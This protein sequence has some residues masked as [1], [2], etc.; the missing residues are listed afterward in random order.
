[1]MILKMSTF[2]NDFF[3]ALADDGGDAAMHDL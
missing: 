3:E 2:P 1:L